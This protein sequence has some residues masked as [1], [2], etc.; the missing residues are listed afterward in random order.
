MFNE[1]PARK[2]RLFDTVNRDHRVLQ[3]ELRRRAADCR[4]T[5]LLETLQSSA[6]VGFGFV[7]REY[8]CRRINETLAGIVGLPVEQ[9]LGQ[10]VA[11]VVPELWQQ[12]R[13]A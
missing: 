12:L 9:I 11:D 3:E 7:D 2:P 1:Q 10:R 8:R 6:P 13:S 5:H 4:I